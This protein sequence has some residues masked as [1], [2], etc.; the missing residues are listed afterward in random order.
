MAGVSNFQYISHIGFAFLLTAFLFIIFIL[1]RQTFIGYGG[2]L[3]LIAYI[4]NLLTCI[5][6]LLTNRN[7]MFPSFKPDNYQILD[8][9]IYI[10]G[11]LL[12]GTSCAMVYFTF[13][14]LIKNKNK[15]TAAT[16]V[17][18]GCLQ[19]FILFNDKI[20]HAYENVPSTCGGIFQFFVHHSPFSGTVSSFLLKFYDDKDTSNNPYHYF[21]IG[22]LC[23]W[24]FI[25]L[26]G[27]D[28]I[29]GKDG[30]IAFAGCFLYI[31]LRR[32]FKWTGI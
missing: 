7:Y 6:I 25:A 21:A 22:F 32:F 31:N 10:F 16:L 18:F 4:A 15:L 30:F 23:G 28:N 5:V 12:G 20:G 11:P 14:F 1:F 13:E 17:S 9:Y 19:L 8:T 26:L 2:R 3:G 29:G 24:I 27:L